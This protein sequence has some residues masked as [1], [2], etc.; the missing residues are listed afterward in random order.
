MSVSIRIHTCPEWDA[1]APKS[2]PVIVPRARR[3]IF[4]HTAGHAPDYGAG[5]IHDVA[6]AYA[7]ARAVQHY[8]MDVNGW[9]DSG[10]NFLVTR[11]GVI[12][13][14][15]WL[16]VSAIQAGRM[17]LSAHCPGQNGN[18]GVEHEHKGSEPMTKAQREASARLMAW[19]SDQYG[20]RSILPVDPHSK[21]VQTSCPANL[22]GDIA[23]IRA[24]A[25]TILRGV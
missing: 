15:R 2:D 23:G 25:L 3:I 18:I 9:N 22:A 12:V 1:R 21:Y 24:R 7:Y 16:T 13:Q 20:L 14:G 4:H 17:V 11:A 6:E 10:H 8:H 19:V 5:T